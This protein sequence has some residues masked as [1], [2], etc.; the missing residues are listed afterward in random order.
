MGSVHANQYL[1]G[2]GVH[3]EPWDQSRVYSKYD[4]VGVIKHRM[5][6]PEEDKKIAPLL[7]LIRD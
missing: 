3:Q 2:F 4:V 7:K 1:L 5:R 6:F